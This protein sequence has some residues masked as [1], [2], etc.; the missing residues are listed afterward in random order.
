MATK[1]KSST[2]TFR[3]NNMTGLLNTESEENNYLTFDPNA[4]YG[5]GLTQ[6]PFEFRAME[7]WMPINRGG[8]S[9]TFGYDQFFDTT[10]ASSITG[11]TRFNKS[12]GTSLFIFSQGTKVYKLVSG[13]KTDIGATVSNGAYLD[14]TTAKDKLIITDG[15][16]ASSTYDGTTVAALVNAPTRL[17]QTIFAQNRLWGFGEVAPDESLLYYSDAD[18]LDNMASNFVNCNCNDG[19]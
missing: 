2:R 7:N 5:A 11:L 17:R 9:V 10:V 16:G 13:V 1:A 6:I 14:F 8:L 19:Q 15:V 12:D 4:N 18:T 3:L